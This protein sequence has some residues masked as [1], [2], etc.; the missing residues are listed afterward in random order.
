MVRLQ[1]EKW[2]GSEGQRQ[3]RKNVATSKSGVRRLVSLCFLLALVVL[4][5]VKAA[6]PENV[7]RAFKALGVPLETEAGAIGK[8]GTNNAVADAPLVAAD[9]EPEVW[10]VA[11]QDLAVR[12]VQRLSESQLILLARLHFG[13]GDPP[14]REGAEREG[15]PAERE[16][17]DALLLVGQTVVDESR[18][19]LGTANATADQWREP[20]ESFAE[21]WSGML[22]AESIATATTAKSGGTA[23]QT[24]RS[25]AFEVML[26]EAIDDRLVDELSDAAFWKPRESVAFFR[27]LQK[28]ER[29]HLSGRSGMPSGKAA[30]LSTQQLES[31]SLRL[32]GRI[33]GFRGEVHRVEHTRR[34]S[35]LADFENGELSDFYTLWIRGEDRTVQPVAVYVPNTVA[36]TLALELPLPGQS[37]D[38]E[39]PRSMISVVAIVG[40]RL[41]YRASDSIEVAPTLFATTIQDETKTQA[42]VEE[43]PDLFVT[44]AKIGFVALAI[45]LVLA[46]VMMSTSRSNRR[47]GLNIGLIGLC[48]MPG[49]SAAFAFGQDAQQ[50][51]PWADEEASRRQ[52][53]A[54]QFVDL[55]SH[56]TLTAIEEQKA[57]AADQRALP[58]EILNMLRVFRQFGWARSFE[59]FRQGLDLGPARLERINIRGVATDCAAVAVTRQQIQWFQ[60]DDSAR[61]FRV[62]VTYRTASDKTDDIALYCTQVPTAWLKARTLKQPMQIDGFVIKASGDAQKQVCLIAERVNWIVA[63]GVDHDRLVPPLNERESSLADCGWDLAWLDTIANENQQPISIDEAVGYYSF[64]RAVGDSPDSWARKASSSTAQPTDV[65]NREA[66]RTGLPARWKIRLVRGNVV[67]VARE[68]QAALGAE[69]YFQ[70]DGFVSIGDRSIDYITD[71]NQGSK[72][73]IKFDREFPIT[74]VTID[75]DLA[76]GRSADAASWEIG[77]YVSADIVYYRLWAYQSE[78]IARQGGAS[79]QASPLAVL[80]AAKPTTAPVSS[81]T[82]ETGWFG[83]ALGIVVLAILVLMLHLAANPGRRPKLS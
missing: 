78:Y 67:P 39:S 36:Q 30:S 83:V 74:L 28:A 65:L 18:E 27:L 50:R 16:N 11:Y 54:S 3:I 34:I 52:V 35:P 5:M 4:L 7:S 21:L 40:K 49:A 19:K 73:S 25:E 24:V 79:R 20:L 57:V 17:L 72:Q 31:E 26:A 62:N 6:E 66:P 2:Y 29:L 8:A 46:R 61:L 12:V 55:W 69:G 38:F 59:A 42:P 45:G 68:E 41:A 22:D 13:A 71:S 1:S 32:R 76:V 64:I 81:K 14:K 43:D 37:L 44:L 47:R 48:A 60:A 9:G 75:P 53:I 10:Q 70:M 33:V 63:S 58:D 23:E 82:A 56:E 51:P 80:V 77:Q 15:E